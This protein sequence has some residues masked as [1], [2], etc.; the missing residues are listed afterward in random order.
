[1]GMLLWLNARL[2]RQPPLAP[3]TAGL[4]LALNGILPIS[5]ILTAF[6]M[7]SANM[8]ASPVVLGALIVSWIAVLILALA[9]AASAIAAR[10]RQ[11]GTRG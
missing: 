2:N 11:Q 1:M 6:R 7:L 4:I 8:R 10:Y 9:L 3:R 5:L